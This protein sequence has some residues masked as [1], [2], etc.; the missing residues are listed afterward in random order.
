MTPLPRYCPPSC[1]VSRHVPHPPGAPG[2]AQVRGQGTVEYLIVL[3][4][5]GIC[6]SAGSASPLER[7]FGAIVDHHARLTDAVSRP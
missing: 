2:V 4:L 7:L 5:V 1:G 6:L 3:A